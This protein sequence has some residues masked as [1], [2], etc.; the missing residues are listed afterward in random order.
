MIKQFRNRTISR[1][2]ILGL[3]FSITIVV[4][5]LSAAFYFYANRYAQNETREQVASISEDFIHVI[6]QPL[7]NTDIETVE[8]LSHAYL[9]SDLLVGIKISKKSGELIF[10]H[11]PQQSKHITVEQRKVVANDFHLADIELL[12]SSDIF[13]KRQ[14]TQ[15][16]TFVLVMVCVL[17]IIIVGTHYLLRNLLT[18]PLHQLIEGIKNISGGQYELQLSPVPQADINNIISHVNQMTTEIANREQSL[19][20]SEQRFRAIFENAIVGIFQVTQEGIFLRA[21]SALAHILGYPSPEELLAAGQNL[22]KNAVGNSEGTILTETLN[23]RKELRECETQI[24][25]EDASTISVSISARPIY[26]EHGALSYYEG[27]LV[28]ITEKK[29][30]EHALRAREV[31]EAANKAKSEFLANM[32]HE[33]RTPLNI[34]LGFSQLMVREQNLN[35][36]QLTSLETIGRSGEHLLALINDVLEFSKIEAGEV[37]L[38]HESFDLHKFLLDLEDMFKLRTQEKCLFLKAI[39]SAGV[40]RHIR[41][42]QNKLR[43]VLINLLGN[44]VKFTEKGGITLEVQSK[45]AQGDARSGKC[46][47]C[48]S[49]NDTGV[50]I[51]KTEQDKIFDAFFQANGQGAAHQGTG[52]GLPISH[53]FVAMLGGSLE[54][55]SMVGQGTR[56]AFDIPVALTD[57][58]SA[59]TTHSQGRVIGLAKGQPEFRL[60]VAEDNPDSRSVLAML[61]RS[62]GFTVFEA[63]NGREAIEVWKEYNP[64][65]IWMDL[66]MPEMN[67]YQA[68]K[69]IR[70]LPDAN[71]TKIVALT[72]YAF[73]EDREKV[74]EAG[75]DDYV[76]K[77]YTETDI[78]HQLEKHLGIQFQYAEKYTPSPEEAS[79]ESFDRQEIA[80][81]LGALPEDVLTRFD[82]AIR[83]SNQAGIK[84]GIEEIS[85]INLRLGRFLD[86]LAGDFA[87]DEIVRCLDEDYIE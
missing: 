45:E 41:T 3:T 73:K 85:G 36:E 4:L 67:G 53:E 49:V 58:S 46:I 47:L 40:P 8:Y 26:N 9:K 48:F 55:E 15:M 81:M 39:H 68:L 21:N 1:D 19:S 32:S 62:V 5:I 66:F 83:L 86:K 54:V 38:N 10:S 28:D 2:L 72:A 37:E 25:R 52:L 27:S 82:E 23:Q 29:E 78:F 12:F 84:K 51:P 60:L 75:G 13:K 6:T 18:K 57:G 31:A 24:Q 30:K 59:A 33:L 71:K 11:A 65:L 61:L 35:E 20:E 69:E 56:F 42:D 70:N 17:I 44:A 87:Y 43:Q 79:V 50:G 63:G 64:H 77:P 76:R 16:M 14:T 7:W 80:T 34:I 74:L 22:L